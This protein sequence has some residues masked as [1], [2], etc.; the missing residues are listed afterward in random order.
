MTT[1]TLSTTAEGPGTGTRQHA[2]GSGLRLEGLTVTTAEGTRLLD[3]VSWS[4]RA[5]ERLGIIGASGSGKSMTGRAV[6]RMLPRGL[7]A[8][9]RVLLDGEDLLTLPTSRMPQVR[10]TRIALVPQE[11]GAALDPLMKVGR[12]VAGV[13]RVHGTAGG[14]S[15]RGE[16]HRL[17]AQVRID[18]VERVAASYPWQLSGGQRQRVCIAQVLACRPDVIIADEPTTALDATVQAAVLRLL[19]ELVTQTRTALV[20]ISHDLPVVASLCSRVVVMQDGRVVEATTVEEIGSS[21]Q[22]CTRAL[23]A[24]AT[25]FDPAALVQ[26]ARS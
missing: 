5:G 7:T 25:A 10:G 15:V 20:L 12:Q 1:G 17:L 4:V 9:G 6:L 21:T 13:L 2:R 24:A 19:D 18:D 16:V 22:P 26:E 14:S 8:S 23:L 3:G 11:P